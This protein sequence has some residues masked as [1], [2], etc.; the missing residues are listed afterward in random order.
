LK[1]R[2][3]L[4]SVY[5]KD[6][7]VEF[8]RALSQ[9]G[10]EILSTGGTA[11][12]LQDQGI[13]VTQVSEYTGYP[14]ILD[15]RVKTL[16]PKIVGGILALRDNEN[17]LRQLKE[18]E[19]IPIDMVV[20]NLY[21]FLEVIKDPNISQADVLENIDIGGP[22]LLRAA[23]KNFSS[24]AV[25]SSPEQY[26]LVLEDLRNHQGEISS[27]LS[28]SLAL[29]AFQITAYYDSMISSYLKDQISAKDDESLPV[30]FAVPL[31]KVLELRYGENP[32][33]KAAFYQSSPSENIEGIKQLAGIELSYN[34]LLDVD[35]A[36]NTVREF[37]DPCAVILKHSNPCGVAVAQTVVEAYEKAKATDPVSAFGGILGVNRTLDAE[38][39]RRLKGHFLEVLLAP[40]YEPEALEILQTKKKLRVLRFRLESNKHWYWRSALEGVLIQEEDRVLYDPQ[41]L[42]VVT[43]R[44][45]TEAEMQ[46]LEFAWRVVKHVKSNAIVFTNASQTLGVGAG[47]MSRVDAVE[48]AVKKAGKA[49]LSLQGSVLASDAF[50]PFPDG[51]EAAAQAGATAIIQPGGSIRDEEVIAAANKHGLAMVFTKMRHFRH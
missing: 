22:S 5:R 49:G 3:A 48:L 21:P 10:I 20:I 39:A 29:Q 43:Q 12:L 18:L 1:I 37:A 42:E 16:H 47:Q 8:A 15:G 7:I 32:H 34:N 28:A 30:K 45:P 6:G 4:I 46:A 9:Y 14:E 11:R 23:A 51:V 44:K 35:G 50:F 36:I 33:Q 17:H 26:P 41:A 27:E 24:V 38:L 13:A 31:H 2:R 25:V 19:I 40:E